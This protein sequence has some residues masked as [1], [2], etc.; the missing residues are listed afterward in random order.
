MGTGV[1]SVVKLVAVI[2]LIVGGL[3]WGL[4]GAFHY[5]LVEALFGA[6][7]ITRVVYISVGVAAVLILIKKLFM[8]HM[9]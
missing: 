4:V 9:D 7:L 1:F 3:N 6:G 2:L 5:N 8:K